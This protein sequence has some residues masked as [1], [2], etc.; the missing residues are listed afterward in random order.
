VGLD[1]TGCQLDVFK[2]SFAGSHELF[3]T[4]LIFIYN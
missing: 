2:F 3:N 1:G 4:Q